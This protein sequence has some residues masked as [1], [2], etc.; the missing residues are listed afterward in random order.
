MA[1]KVAYKLH[2]AFIDRSNMLTFVL[3]IWIQHLTP[4]ILQCYC[5]ALRN[6]FI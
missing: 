6:E 3:L 1:E 5:T 4:F 2:T